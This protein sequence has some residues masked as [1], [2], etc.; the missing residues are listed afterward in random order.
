MYT[1][2]RDLQ[3]TVRDGKCS[4]NGFLPQQKVFDVMVLREEEQYVKRFHSYQTLLRNSPDT[5]SAIKYHVQAN[6]G[7]QPVQRSMKRNMVTICISQLGSES[8]HE[9]SLNFKQW[10]LSNNAV[11]NGVI[12][13]HV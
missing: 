3:E 7:L 11:K 9:L 8:S 2:A 5:N 13:Y 10:L 12:I 1:V 6:H 4:P